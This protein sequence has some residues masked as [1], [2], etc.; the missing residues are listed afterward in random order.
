[1]YVLRGVYLNSF[2]VHACSFAD[3]PTNAN[4]MA[5]SFCILD[6]WDCSTLQIAWR[7]RDENNR[8]SSSLYVKVQV[9]NSLLGVLPF[10]YMSHIPTCDLEK[11]SWRIMPSWRLRITRGK[12]SPAHKPRMPSWK[13]SRA[14]CEYCGKLIGK[15]TNIA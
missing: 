7:I 5:W 15:Y 6:D 11:H 3:Q 12:L 4:L 14:S 1:M 9:I 10:W 13:W 2:F 8:S